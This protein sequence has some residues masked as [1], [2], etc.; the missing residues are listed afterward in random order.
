ML[1]WLCFCPAIYFRAFLCLVNR[2]MCW[3]KSAILCRLCLVKV[4][5]P[6]LPTNYF[7]FQFY[8]NIFIMSHFGE[9]NSC[10]K[11]SVTE[12]KRCILSPSAPFCWIK[13]RL[14][15][16]TRE[17]RRDSFFVAHSLE[18]TLEMNSHIF[19]FTLQERQIGL[20]F[21]V[22]LIQVRI[23]GMVGDWEAEKESTGRK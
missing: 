14:N 6:K 20:W 17:V 18:Q 13:Y 23:K 16:L 10:G 11:L 5:V 15:C 2:I 21:L 7:F 8:W 9:W 22:A 12:L 4:L 3:L 19:I 1:T